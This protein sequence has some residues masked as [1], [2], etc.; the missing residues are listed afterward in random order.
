MSNFSTIVLLP[1][2]IA[3]LI[4][5]LRFYARESAASMR[6]PSFLLGALTVLIA[7]GYLILRVTHGMPFYGSVGFGLA[8]LALLATSIFRMFLI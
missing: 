2:I 7:G 1:F 4:F 8:G 5:V 6:N 3:F